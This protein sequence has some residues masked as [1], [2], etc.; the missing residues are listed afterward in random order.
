MPIIRRRR[1]GR[2]R[3]IFQRGFDRTGGVWG[4]FKQA[5][6]SEKKWHDSLRD[7]VVANG[8]QLVGST[9]T[10]TVVSINLIPQGTSAVNRD[11][12]KCVLRSY[13][14]SGTL[15]TTVTA[16]GDYHGYVKLWL[17]QDTQANGANPAAL[18]VFDI[19]GTSALTHR[20]LYNVDRFKILDVCRFQINPPATNGGSELNGTTTYFECQGKLSIPLEFSSTTGAITELKSNNLMW[21]AM[22]D[23]LTQGADAAALKL[24]TRVRFTG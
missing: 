4:R 23:G 5:P 8:L 10:P 19:D 24:F 9:G 14:C 12:R 18:D 3:R 16:Q 20:N 11:G 17:V 15:K 22:V 1:Y 13:Y 21:I 6:T 2:R 7:L